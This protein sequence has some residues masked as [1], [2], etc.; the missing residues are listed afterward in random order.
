MYFT[1]KKDIWFITK[2]FIDLLENIENQIT[3]SFK[4]IFLL[5]VYFQLIVLNPNKSCKILFSKNNKLSNI[6]VNSSH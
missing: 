2:Y 3:K 1:G 5:L 6:R 4:S